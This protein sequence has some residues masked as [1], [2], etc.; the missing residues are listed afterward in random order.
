MKAKGA[1]LRGKGQAWEIADLDFDD[2]RQNELL[3]RVVASGLCHCPDG[4]HL[5]V[6]QLQPG[7]RDVS[8]KNW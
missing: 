4:W 1:V 8:G 3:I 5:N 6:C 7:R 2:P